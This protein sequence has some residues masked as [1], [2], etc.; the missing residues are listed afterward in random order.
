MRLRVESVRESEKKGS[1]LF[2]CM[3]FGRTL[4]IRTHT[5]HTRIHRVNQPVSF[6]GLSEV[7]FDFLQNYPL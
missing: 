5:T 7:K 6:N 2:I 4:H 1:F 3:V